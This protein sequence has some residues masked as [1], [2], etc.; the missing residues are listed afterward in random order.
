MAPNI[1]IIQSNSVFLCRVRYLFLK[2]IWVIR[3]LSLLF[4]FGGINPPLQIATIFYKKTNTDKGILL[5]CSISLFKLHFLCLWIFIILST[6]ILLLVYTYFV[7]CFFGFL[8]FIY[9]YLAAYFK[10]V[11]S[12]FFLPL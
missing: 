9:P 10:R 5:Y 6:L 2:K 8:P 4:Y 1:R 12:N 3:K 7:L 11:S